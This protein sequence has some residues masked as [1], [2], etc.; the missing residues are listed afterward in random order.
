VQTN[1]WISSTIT[2]GCFRGNEKHITLTLYTFT[3]PV[4]TFDT[5]LMDIIVS[6]LK[7]NCHIPQKST[8]SSSL[9]GQSGTPSQVS[10]YAMHRPVVEHSN[11]MSAQRE[12]ISTIVRHLNT[13]QINHC[14]FSISV[15]QLPPRHARGGVWGYAKISAHRGVEPATF[16]SSVVRVNQLSHPTI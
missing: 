11:S 16:R 13:F 10:S 2:V 5:T 4:G 14:T 6:L 3:L 12:A 1:P 8:S 7:S 9:F 15:V